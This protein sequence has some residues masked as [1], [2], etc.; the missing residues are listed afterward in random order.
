MQ[1][2]ISFQREVS[3]RTPCRIAAQMCGEVAHPRCGL[4]TGTE[5][6]ILLRERHTTNLQ[7]LAEE[8]HR[9]SH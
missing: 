7:L 8:V 4:S 5:L 2:G 6:G 1:A 9:L 3:L